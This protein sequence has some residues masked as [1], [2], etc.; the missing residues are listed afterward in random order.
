M[1]RPFKGKPGP[2]RAAG[3]GC[4]VLAVALPPAAS[5]PGRSR[6]AAPTNAPRSHGAPAAFTHGDCRALIKREARAAALVPPRAEPAATGG[7]AAAAGWRGLAGAGR[8]APLLSSR[9][10]K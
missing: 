7:G 8:A 3:G 9:G 6:S 5:F 1:G 4:P 10:T 2:E